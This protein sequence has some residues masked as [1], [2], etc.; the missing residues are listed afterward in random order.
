MMPGQEQNRKE[1]ID[2]ILQ[3]LEELEYGSIQIVIHDS[4]ITQID[5]L[6]KQR[7]SSNGTAILSAV[8][9]QSKSR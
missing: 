8:P 7:F 5:L 2:F 6:K 3:S 4:K 9:P 1:A